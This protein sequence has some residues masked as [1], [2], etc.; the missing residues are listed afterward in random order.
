MKS[1]RIRSYTELL[2]ISPYSVQ[3]RENVGKMRTRIT[4]N[5]DTFYAV[6]FAILDNCILP[7]YSSDTYLPSSYSHP[8]IEINFNK[9]Y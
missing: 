3:M 4:P 8:H 1:A 5:T 9:H 2:R 6:T 7:I